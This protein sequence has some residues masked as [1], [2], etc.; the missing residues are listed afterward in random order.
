M[1]E[2]IKQKQTD[3]IEQMVIFN[4]GQ[5]EFGV[6]ILKM[7]GPIASPVPGII[8]GGYNVDTDVSD[9]A[10]TRITLGMNVHFR[11]FLKTLM[12]INY[13]I[14]DSEAGDLGNV[15]LAETQIAF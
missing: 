12:R 13:Q 7:N 5:E 2:D 3:D 9:N 1:A 14:N 6:N 4:L 8:Y 11:K 15:F 10:K